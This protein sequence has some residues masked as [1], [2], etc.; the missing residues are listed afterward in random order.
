MTIV[1]QF[2][3]IYV[4][5]FKIIDDFCTTFIETLSLNISGSKEGEIE[6]VSNLFP[7]QKK[8]QVKFFWIDSIH[9]WNSYYNFKL[10]QTFFLSI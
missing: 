10:F 9:F 5:V 1:L 3:V 6:N 4:I 2:V 8:F 7:R